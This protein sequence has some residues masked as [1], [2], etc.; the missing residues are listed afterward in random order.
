MPD[1]DFAVD[2]GEIARVLGTTLLSVE[3][4]IVE[5]GGSHSRV[6]SVRTADEDY[7]LRIPKGR[8]G[9]QTAYVEERIPSANWFSQDWATA[10]ARQAGVPAPE[11]VR[12]KRFASE[13]EPFVIMKKL[14][15]EHISDF[16]TWNGC[17]YNEAEFGTILS[18]LHAV[19][20]AG[21]GPIDDFGTTY[22]TTWAEFLTAAA[23]G[24]LKRCAK[25]HS[26]DPDVLQAFKS[27]CLPL[28]SDLHIDRPSFLHLE[29]LG[30][31]NILYEPSTRR[32]TGLLDYEDCIGGDPLYEFEWMC[33][34][35]GHRVSRQP[36]FDFRRFEETYGIWP[37][38]LE[39]S[40]LYR[41]L[42]FL[43]KLTSI[44]PKSERAKDHN[45]KILE[46]IDQLEQIPPTPLFKGG[47]EPGRLIVEH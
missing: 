13:T 30:F 18:K 3:P 40:L 24:M 22:F 5:K 16:D 21:Y 27:T 2:A 8:Q 33:Y 14:E 31:A 1:V 12:S 10:A 17:P 46:C 4:L 44:A 7:I 47:T 39:R 15:G 35:F 26:L 28:L 11:I 32:I 19:T 42:I 20:P 23:E 6:F 25:R 37:E 41:V 45:Q 29:S 43:D 9:F 36:Y 38:N 34:Y